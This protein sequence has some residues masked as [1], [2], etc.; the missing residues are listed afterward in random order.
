[1]G[2]QARNASRG[3]RQARAAAE[4]RRKRLRLLTGA[5]AVVIVGLLVAI[6]VSLVNAA[7]GS[8]PDRDGSQKK[9][10]TP[11]TATAGG[12]LAVG[13]ATAPVRLEVYLDY[14]CPYCGRFEQANAGELERLVAEGTVR[15]ELYP[16]SFLDKAS[17]GTRYSTR[18]ANAVATVADRA[19]GKVLAFNNAL[20]TR[21]PAEGT[22]GLSD[23]EIAALAR[24]AGVPTDVVNLFTD[25]IFEPWV[26]ASTET[27]LKTGVS[28][29]PTV[30]INGKVFKGDLFTVGPLTQAVAAAKG[31]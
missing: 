27:V 16:L 21:Q 7:G 2:K 24:S 6:V 19:P 31:Q 12:A 29:T 23:D 9:M 15:L 28:S 3:V 1:M 20:F 8:A 30:K 5:G 10:V 25:G 4:Q 26:A 18:T 11:A 13:S 22:A 14:M 17:A